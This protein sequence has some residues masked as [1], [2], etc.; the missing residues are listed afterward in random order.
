[1]L[2]DT[3]IS[4]PQSLK[5]RMKSVPEP[6][7]RLTEADGA[8]LTPWLYPFRTKQQPSRQF[9]KVG[10]TW[11]SIEYRLSPKNARFLNFFELG[12]RHLLP[13]RPPS[14]CGWP[15]PPKTLPWAAPLPKLSYFCDSPRVGKLSCS[16]KLFS[17]LRS[18]ELPRTTP[19][20]PKL[21]R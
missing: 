5:N 1:M 10:L 14:S 18:S 11:A 20:A 13:R 8:S 16:S 6:T 12:G 19:V 3:F 2:L 4:L 9:V 7:S 21:L 17:L 15:S